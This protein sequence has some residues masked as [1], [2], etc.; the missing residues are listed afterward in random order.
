[1]LRF[2]KSRSR[3]ISLAD[4]NMEKRPFLAVPHRMLLG[5]DEPAPISADGA[6]IRR[7]PGRGT[8]PSNDQIVVLTRVLQAAI[9]FAMRTGTSHHSR[10]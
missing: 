8:I 1:V 3:A 9:L 2:L 4:Y 6:R 10:R 7:F 5:D